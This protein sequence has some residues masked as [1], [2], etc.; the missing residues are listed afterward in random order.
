MW[1]YKLVAFIFRNMQINDFV[2]PNFFSGSFDFELSGTQ[3]TF[4]Q[5]SFL[6]RHC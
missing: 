2:M 5:I 3:V 4:I 6:L 1:K